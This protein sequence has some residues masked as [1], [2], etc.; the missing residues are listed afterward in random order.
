[1]VLVTSA[2]NEMSYINSSSSAATIFGGELELRKALVTFSR[3]NT[4]LD[5]GLNVSYL[6]SRQKLE[7]VKWDDLSFDPNKKRSA[8]EGASP[9]L[10]NSDV[11]FRSENSRGRKMMA[12]VL[13][14]Y[15]M[16]RISSFGAGQGNEDIVERFIPKLDFISSFDLN[17]HFS[18]SIKAT[19]LLNAKYQLTKQVDPLNGPKRDA[20]IGSYQKG[21]TTSIGLTYTF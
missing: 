16:S 20:L 2:A 7:D 11:T 21:V 9:W 13:F 14:N 18:L 3:A 1:M 4:L 10:V 6:Y 5:L 12:T 8:L 19:N 17:D 15:N